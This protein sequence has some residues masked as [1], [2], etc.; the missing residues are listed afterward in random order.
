MF[1]AF[2]ADH[3]RWMTKN[4][5]LWSSR[6]PWLAVD[7]WMLLVVICVWGGS[8]A[9]MHRATNVQLAPG[10]TGRAAEL[11]AD[12]GLADKAV[13]SLLISAGDGTVVDPAAGSAA[14]AAVTARLLGLPGVTAVSAPVTS[15]DG[16]AMLLGITLAEGADD[17]APM[18]GAAAAVAADHPGLRLDVVGGLTI[19]AD[20]DRQLAGDFQ[21]ALVLS[22]PITVLILLIAFGAL[23]AAGVPVLL[24]ASAV[25]SAVGLYTVASHVLPD[26]GSGAELILLIGMAVGVDYSMFYLKREREERRRGSSAGDALIIAASTAGRAVVTSGGAVMVAMGGLFLLGDL[27]FSSMAAG[28]IIVVA[29]AVLG[30]LT[31]LPAVL[32]LLGDRVD[33]PRIPL[34][35]RVTM[36]ERPARWWPLMLRPALKYPVITLVV[37]VA[38]M[39]LLAVPAR[40]LNLRSSTEDDLPQS[41][42]SVAGFQRLVA[43]F[44]D[45]QSG[46][47]VVVHGDDALVGDAAA[48]I[49]V[50]A[51]MSPMPEIRTAPNLAV[52][53]IPVPYRADSTQARAAL[54]QLRSVVI[55]QAVPPIGATADLEVVVGGG[56][57]YGVDYVDELRS[58]APLV[59]GFVLLMT[60]LL[61]TFSFSSV[62]VGL[63]TIAANLLS[64]G[65]AFGVLVLVFQ[66]RWGADML[67]FTFTGGVIAWIPVFLFVILF[68]L[69]MDYHVLVISRIKE[70]VDRG[71]QTREAVREGIIG[72]AG[73]ITGAAAVMVGVFAIFA[74]L[75]MVEFKELGVG[76]ATAVFL[77]AI[78][79]R[80]LILPALMTLLGSANWWSPRFIGRRVDRPVTV[81]AGGVTVRVL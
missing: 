46:L 31:V 67:G 18:L 64:A 60:F 23:C 15:V 78:V 13:E 36:S 50:V 62:V 79:V 8:V 17:P 81:A 4:A 38:G 73:V 27:N 53:S 34:L 48:R 9:G 57:A 7:A 16:T 59:I 1:T 5:A 26:G 35:S 61:M 49:A 14:A 66:S 43:A 24:G 58:R 28:A 22:L 55:P 25:L 20:V 70:G 12:S 71:L 39:V 45:E 40:D 41:M 32:A 77:D 47:T 11:I 80:I 3:A 69:S 68:G 65:A 6:H 51:G 44:P 54:T 76:L 29:L 21:S 42:P 2:R 75:S 19:G 37:G 72:S 30:S 33:K 56:V 52:L 63:V 74:G 10:D